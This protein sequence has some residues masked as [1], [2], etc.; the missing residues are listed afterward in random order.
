MSKD[1]VELIEEKQKDLYKFEEDIISQISNFKTLFEV[2]S[3]NDEILM[4]KTVY[5]ML[6][7]IQGRLLQLNGFTINLFG[8]IS[9]EFNITECYENYTDEEGKVID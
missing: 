1:N 3:K 8:L 5:D 4:S 2:L 6:D 9:K 7:V